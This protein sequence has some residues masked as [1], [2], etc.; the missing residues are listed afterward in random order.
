MAVVLSLLAL[1]AGGALV[2]QRAPEASDCP[3]APALA[4]MIARLTSKAPEPADVAPAGAER[5][6]V[7]FSRGATRYRVVV[8][9]RG[10]RAGV[11]TLDDPGATCASLAEATALTIAVIVD[12]EGVKLAEPATPPEAAQAPL[13]PVAETQAPPPAAVPPP[14]A[15]FRWAI[16]VEARVGAAIAIL[17]EVAPTG[18]LAVELRPSSIVSVEVGALFIPSQ[19]LALERGSVDV[20]LLAGAANACVWPYAEAAR[21][22][23]CIG[24]AAG[25]VRADGRG[26]PTESGASRPWLAANAALAAGGPIAWRVGWTGRAGVVVPTRRESFGIEGAGVAYEAPSVGGLVAAGLTMSIR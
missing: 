21:V 8:R 1:T 11:R 20:W 23:A 2:V 10:S 25:T 6:D 13:P 12:P 3:D 16:G 17:R 19:S 22:G 24:L 4:A 18:T 5:F 7:E 15:A 26:Y 9:T 14:P